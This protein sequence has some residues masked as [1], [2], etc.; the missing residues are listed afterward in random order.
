MRVVF[1]LSGTTLFEADMESVP[2]NESI[3]EFTTGTYK[4]GL[5]A[6]SL[7]SIKVGEEWPVRYVFD[8]EKALTVYISVD[9]YELISENTEH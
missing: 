6:G 8:S 9:G 2:P 3:V 7:I 5:E 4:K 1:E